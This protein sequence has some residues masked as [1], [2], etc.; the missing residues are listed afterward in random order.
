M[1]SPKYSPQYEKP[2]LAE[3]LS[4]LGRLIKGVHPACKAVTPISRRDFD[5]LVDSIKENGLIRPIEVSP[6]RQLVDGRCRVLACFVAGVEIKSTNIV[7]TAV[8]PWT[9]AASNNARRHLTLDQK[10]MAAAE[11][12]K[13]ERI[14][15]AKRK[16]AGAATAN[17]Q[18]KTTLGTASAPS[19]MQKLARAPKAIEIVAKRENVAREALALAEKIC[20]TNQ[21]LADKVSQGEVSLRDA[22]AQSGVSRPQQKQTHRSKLLV[23]KSVSVS[24]ESIAS[25]LMSEQAIF[26]DHQTTI[27]ERPDGI[28]LVRDQQ[29]VVVSHPSVKDSYVIFVRQLKWA[30]ASPGS[31]MLALLDSKQGAEFYAVTQVK[32]ALSASPNMRSFQ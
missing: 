28:R 1:S 8:L 12:L 27:S 25:L 26:Q 18:K 5:D 2:S 19:A 14:Q 29:C 20:K 11:L 30:C 17:L 6:S 13:A 31:S 4:P 3:A 23:C 21:R 24:K 32:K 10:V 16:V 9:I 7:E 22:A 15:A